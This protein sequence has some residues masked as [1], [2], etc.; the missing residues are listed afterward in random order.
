MSSRWISLLILSFCL[1]GPAR[2]DYLLID[3][4]FIEPEEGLVRS[5]YNNRTF[6]FGLGVGHAFEGGAKAEGYLARREYES[7]INALEANTILY[8]MGASVKQ[9]LSHIPDWVDFYIGAGIKSVLFETSIEDEQTETKSSN[10]K[11]YLSFAYQYEFGIERPI[12]MLDS[13]LRFSVAREH[14]YKSLF[15]NF[16]LDGH[17]YK[18][19]W[20]YNL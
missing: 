11:R 19:S 10:K 18:V 12:S 15:G 5:I 6:S 13:A 3:V 8:E 1:S 16:N 17:I 14:I 4:A 2:A 9:T 7:R 20:A